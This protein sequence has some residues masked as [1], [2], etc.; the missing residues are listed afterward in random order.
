MIKTQSIQILVIHDSQSEAEPL[1]N[2]LR[3]QSLAVHSFFIASEGELEQQLTNKAFDLALI[4]Q[5]TQ[6]VDILACL[7][8]LKNLQPNLV[9][10]L[11]IPSWDSK[12]INQSLSLGADALSLITEKDLILKYSMQLLE[13]SRL[14]HDSKLLQSDLK[15]TLGRCQLLLDSSMDAI[16]YV[17]EGMHI[18]ANPAYAELFGYDDIDDLTCIPFLDLVIQDDL[19]QLKSK[20]KSYHQLSDEEIV[21]Q[22]QHSN[23]DFFPVR[24]FLSR[25]QYDSESCLQIVIRKKD[26]DNRELQEKLKQIQQ[27]DLLTGLFNQQAFNDQ[28][29]HCFHKVLRKEQGPHALYYVQLTNMMDIK[30]DLGIS[31]ADLVLSDA[32]E[33][34]KNLTQNEGYL[35]RLADD[36]FS[37]LTPIKEA[38]KPESVA[39]QLYHCL[40]EYLYEAEGVTLTLKVAIG[41]GTLDNSLEQAKQVLMEA[42]HAANAAADK[43]LPALR[44]DRTDSANVADSSLIEQVKHALQYDHFRLLFQPIISLRDDPQENYEVLMRLQISD[45]S[46][47]PYEVIR[48]ADAAGLAV[49]LDQWVAEHALRELA[50]HRQQGNDTRLFLHVTPATMRDA[51]FLPWLNS[52]LRQYR[53][54]GDA[55]V[56]QISE[57]NALTYL[58]AAKA[59]GRALSVLKCRLAISHF[60][61]MP[62]SMS[63]LKH[64]NI[65]Y[66]K[67]DASFVQNLHKGD[68]TDQL[69]QLIKGVQQQ[70]VRAIVPQIE[71]AKALNIL[72]SCGADYIQGYYVQKPS[73]DMTFDFSS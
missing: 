2:L 25:A 60:G 7:K 32:A 63:L 37:W 22:V 17:H 11:L 68:T 15:E 73:E 18:F 70:E 49:E 45:Q 10:L 40:T 12:I 33:Q 27:Q 42:H 54:P 72:W 51:A 53:L 19:E 58:K 9:K 59:F 28:I 14:R 48:A 67:L 29:E 65:D 34:L 8:L 46:H 1:V 57:E 13:L 31:A 3:S 23:G 52:M 38:V 39:M 47:G 71:E 61:H 4:K 16:A 66:V 6:T 44:Y 5:D 43:Q 41:I 56:F 20:F 30:T 64:L 36:V 55:L 50:Q 24:M 26:A 21:T 62:D 35:G 69:K